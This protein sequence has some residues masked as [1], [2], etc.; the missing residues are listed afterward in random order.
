MTRRVW[1][2]EPMQVTLEI[3]DELAGVLHEMEPRDD[4][5]MLVEAVCG[6]YARGRISSGKGARI[7]GIDRFEFQ[8]ELAKREIPIHYRLEDLKH[9]IAFAR[10]E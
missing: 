8:E 2:A 6:L 3:P 4:R 7:L 10:G 1:Q 9:D 5:G